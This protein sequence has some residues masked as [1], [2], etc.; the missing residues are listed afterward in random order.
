MLLVI[1]TPENKEQVTVSW[2]EKYII[3]TVI[4]SVNLKHL[5]TNIYFLLLGTKRHKLR[6]YH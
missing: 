2:S 1:V 5:A 4:L 3:F 6:R